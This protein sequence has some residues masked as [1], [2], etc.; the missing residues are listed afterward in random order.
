MSDRLT[1]W[2]LEKLADLKIPFRT[3]RFYFLLLRTSNLRPCML[4]DIGANIGTYTLAV[5]GIQPTREVI[6]PHIMSLPFFCLISCC[7]FAHL[8]LSISCLP[9][10]C[11]WCR[12]IKSC[13]HKEESPEEL[14]VGKRSSEVDLQCCQVNISLEMKIPE[15]MF[16][17]L[18]AVTREV[19][20]TLSALFTTQILRGL[21][22]WG[23]KSWEWWKIQKSFGTRSQL[24]MENGQQGLMQR[25]DILA[26]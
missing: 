5:A 13:L 21:R 15:W 6:L 17:L 16:S 19:F 23:R 10:D 9:G 3:C 26:I 7:H 14:L 24:T 20:S 22:W 12:R 2:L 25:K 8:L 1:K 18:F 11:C 4:S